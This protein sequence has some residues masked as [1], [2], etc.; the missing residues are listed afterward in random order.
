MVHHAETSWGAVVLPLTMNGV[1][2]ETTK[3]VHKHE[4]SRSDLEAVCGA[5]S[6]LK[7][8]QLR[9]TAV[10]EAITDHSADKCA[11]C[12]EDVGGY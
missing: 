6:D 1:L 4:Q 2:N 3:I 11:R 12:F 10:K 7:R 8:D 9:M 5:T